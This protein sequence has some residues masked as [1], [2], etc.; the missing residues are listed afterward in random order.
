MLLKQSNT[1]GNVRITSH[2]GTLAWRLYLSGYPN[3]LTGLQFQSMRPL[4]RRFNVAGNNKTYLGLYVKYPTLWPDFFRQNSMEVTDIKYQWN[5]SSGGRDETCQQTDRHD[6][7]K[8]AF[9]DYANRPNKSVMP[10]KKATCSKNRF[11][12]LLRMNRTEYFYK[13]NTSV[14]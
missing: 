14:V 1:L 10:E 6:E 5:L 7:G 12:F 3:S 13:I 8:D 9:C 4:L 2:C 11:T